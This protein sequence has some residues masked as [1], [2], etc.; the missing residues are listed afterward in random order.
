MEIVGLPTEEK[1]VFPVPDQSWHERFFLSYEFLTKNAPKFPTLLSL[2]FI[3]LLRGHPRGGDNF[4]SLFPLFKVS[5]APF[6]TLRVA[7]PLGAPRQA[8]LDFCGSQIPAKF[9]QDLK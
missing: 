9:P 3:E 1:G 7:T 2:F 6:L 8:P 4:T 5:K